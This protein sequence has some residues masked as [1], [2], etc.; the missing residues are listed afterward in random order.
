MTRSTPRTR[1]TVEALE[2]RQMMA[3]SLGSV[4]ALRPTLVL[5]AAQKTISAPPVASEA[6]HLM[7][8]DV[9]R[10][11]GIRINHNETFVRTRRKA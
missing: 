2:D 3:T 4:V 11:A 1:L 10:F 6:G 8:G 9:S 7:V 5:E